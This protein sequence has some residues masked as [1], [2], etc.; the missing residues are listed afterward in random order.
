MNDMEIP[1]VLKDIT[2]ELKTL[3][4]INRIQT[5]NIIENSRVLTSLFNRKIA[6][7]KAIVSTMQ[8]HQRE[9]FDS[10]FDESLKRSYA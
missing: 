5:E 4:E 9:I 3:V 6:L 1:S 10:V 8:T 7:E 2:D